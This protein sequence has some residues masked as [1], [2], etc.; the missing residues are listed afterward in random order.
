MKTDYPKILTEEQYEKE[1]PIIEKELEEKREIVFLNSFDAN[2]IY[3]ECYVQDN[4]DKNMVILHGFTEFS[5]KYRETVHYFLKLKYNVFVFDQ[6]GHGLSHRE[7]EDLTLIHINSF[8]NYVKDLDFIIE[9]LVKIKGKDLPIHLFSHSMGGAVS[10]LYMMQ[11]CSEIEKAVLSSPMI[12]PVTKGVPRFFVML[13]VAFHGIFLGWKRPFVFAGKFDPD[14][15]IKDTLDTSPSRFN[16]T[17]EIRKSKKEYQSAASTNKWMWDALAVQDKL[18]R[19]SK[20]KKIESHVLIV[21]AEK[22]TIVKNEFHP[23]VARFIKNSKLVTVP[24]AKHNIFFSS[25]KTLE[26]YYSLVF[27]FLI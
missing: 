25:G 18:M 1:M 3:C 16:S 13:M 2:P 17:M 27:D 6:R 4:A 14:V 24:C 7:A 23:K 15:K 19:K 9:N 8:K 10:L 20:L 11:N 26:D 5:P 21:S 22:E 12:S